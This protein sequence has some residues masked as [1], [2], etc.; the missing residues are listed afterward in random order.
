MTKHLPIDVRRTHRGDSLTAILDRQPRQPR[1]RRVWDSML[2]SETNPG[3]D[4]LAELEAQ[5]ADDMRQLA[6]DYVA[7]AESIARRAAVNHGT[8]PAQV[9]AF[10]RDEDEARVRAEVS[11]EEVRS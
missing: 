5:A 9:A 8:T 4:R 10:L 2:D 1:N 6:V 3:H 11:D 7:T